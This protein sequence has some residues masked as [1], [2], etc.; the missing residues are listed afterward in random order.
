MESTSTTLAV[1][2]LQR[3]LA[4]DSLKQHL[5]FVHIQRFFELTHRMWPEIARLGQARPL[6]LP[7]QVSDF[8]AS[9][10]SLDSS[11]IQL[12]WHAFGD[13]AEAS[14][15]EMPQL[16]LDDVFRV[17]SHPYNIGLGLL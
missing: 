13:L 3:L 11:L 8:L 6:S 7:P 15:L 5:H 17:H 2:I 16:S 9:V 4:H 14:H 12:T 10:L 1:Q